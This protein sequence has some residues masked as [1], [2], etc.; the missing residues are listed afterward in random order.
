MQHRLLGVQRPVL[1]AASVPGHMRQICIVILVQLPCMW[2]S[3]VPTGAC[4]GQAGLC[5]G[6]PGTAMLL[7]GAV[8]GQRTLR[9]FS[10]PPF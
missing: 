3:T 6:V 9:V 1:H 5:Q 7:G 8:A 4:F 2:D 10:L